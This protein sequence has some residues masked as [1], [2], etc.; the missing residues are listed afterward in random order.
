MHE[1]LVVDDDPAS[2]YVTTR[3]LKAAGFRVREAATGMQGLD[4]ADDSI[5]AMVL[6]VHLPDIH[7]F[8]LCQRLRLR[9][10]ATARL[11]VLHLTAAFVT[12]DDKVRGLDSGAD[13]YLTHP[14][15]PAVLVATVQALV[16]THVAEGAMRRSEAKFKA[17][18]AQAPSG[19]SLL[20]ATGRFS[21]ANPALLTLLGRSLADI[22][23]KR[24]SCFVPPEWIERVDA[25]TARVADAPRHH[26]FPVLSG[27][28]RQVH[29]EWAISS[30][31]EPPL[32]VAVATDILRECCLSSSA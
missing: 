22:V 18:Y 6:D 25:Y 10:D 30:H 32:T 12:D 27:D 23:G 17:I 15:E 5:S 3:L 1:L 28:G 24:V 21:D 4:L 31:V 14:V 2:R 26:E 8:E 20:D 13:A 11:P 16:R 7:G 9:S 29:L 19:I